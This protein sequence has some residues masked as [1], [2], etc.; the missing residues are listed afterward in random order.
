MRKFCTVLVLSLVALLHVAPGCVTRKGAESPDDPAYIA[1]QPIAVRLII[2]NEV[3]DPD[4]P[5]DNVIRCIVRNNT[6]KPVELPDGYA[7][8]TLRGE[9]DEGRALVLRERNAAETK[10]VQVLPGSEA[11][12]FELPLQ[13][14]LLKPFPA[15]GESN[16]E[17]KW[18][19]APRLMDVRSLPA[20]P[21]SPIGESGNWHSV[22]FYVELPFWKS[23]TETGWVESNHAILRVK[24]D[25]QAKANGR[26]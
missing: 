21:E 10:K 24:G 9:I 8:G 5:S 1:K 7:S 26:R 17:W 12:L 6:K 18:D 11:L 4:N 23:E 16:W 22:T 13:E 3:F 19:M 14:I 2:P 25:E 20:P 15:N